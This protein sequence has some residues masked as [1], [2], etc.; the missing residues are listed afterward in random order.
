MKKQVMMIATSLIISVAAYGADNT[1][2][3][4]KNVV[5]IENETIDPSSFGEDADAIDEEETQGA[6]FSAITE[7][8]SAFIYNK[9]FFNVYQAVGVRFNP[10]VFLGGGIGVQVGQNRA[11]QFQLLTDLRVN[12]LDKRVT[13]VFLAQIGYNKVGPETIVNKD[14]VELNDMHMN[15]NLGTGVLFKATEKASFTLNGGYMLFTDFN[16]NMHGGFVLYQ[17][18]IQNRPI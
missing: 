15:I 13:P 4:N 5:T 18:E 17:F 3:E 16:K 1:T 9:T 6:Q 2:P 7:A 10:Y 12:V 14:N 11:Y 8:G